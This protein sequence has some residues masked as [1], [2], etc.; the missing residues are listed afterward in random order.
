MFAPT[1]NKHLQMSKR[2]QKEFNAGAASGS[3]HVDMGGAMDNRRKCAEGVKSDRPLI[4]AYWMG[5][6]STMPT[7]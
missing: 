6:A 7:A 4:R 3:K 1:T 2:E 5:Y